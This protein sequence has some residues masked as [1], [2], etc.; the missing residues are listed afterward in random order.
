VRLTGLMEAAASCGMNQDRVRDIATEMCHLLDLQITL[1]RS[2]VMLADIAGEQ[3]GEYAYRN[4]CLL[5][6]SNEM[7]ELD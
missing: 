7:N 3:S 5:Q 6:L 4:D 2:G 1:L